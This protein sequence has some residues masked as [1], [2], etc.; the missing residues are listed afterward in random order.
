[1]GLR[2]EDGPPAVSR[3]AE[4]IRISL[5][6][7]VWNNVQRGTKLVI[8]S[9]HQLVAERLNEFAAERSALVV[10]NGEVL[11]DLGTAEFSL[12]AEGE[13]CVLQIWSEERNI[14]RRVLSAEVKNGILKLEVLRFGQ[15]KPA[16]LEICANP[17]PASAGVAAGPRRAARAQFQRLLRRLLEK[18]RPGW[19]LQSLVAAP[20]L[21]HSFGPAHVRG[22]IRRGSAAMAV[23]GVSPGEAQATVDGAVSAAVLWM[24]YCRQHYADRVHVEGARL[25]IPRGRSGAVRLRLSHLNHELAKWELCEFDQRAETVEEVSARDAGN[26]STRLVQAPDYARARERFAEAMALVRQILP[27]AEVEIVSAA[28]VSFRYHGLEFARAAVREVAGSFRTEAQL[29]FA[30]M[31][32]LAE[33]GA[34]IVVNAATEA[35]FREFVRQLSSARDGASGPSAGAAVAPAGVG[36]SHPLHRAVPER[37]L[38]AN[39]RRDPSLLDERLDPAAIY[40]QVPAFAAT[41]RAMIDLLGV[42]REGRLA[43][44]ELKVE[45]DIHLPLQGLDYWARVRWHQQRGEF[46]RFG[47]FPGREL[48][49]QPPLLLM[50]APCLHVH[51]TTDCLLRHLSPAIEWK[52]L[53]L[54]EHWRQGIRVIFRKT[55]SQGTGTRE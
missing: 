20:D 42:T 41:D 5:A 30:D 40:A 1:L 22:L 44:I 4:K 33:G 23:L 51:P 47:Y 35:R 12:R 10:E 48:T 16:K 14:V 46:Q 26:F 18:S 8:A 52:L 55:R 25:F 19:K 37:W 21:E 31:A 39:L 28:E 6:R 43:V 53:G 3:A 15:T 29:L 24:E 7:G 36:R 45:E 32:N 50:A 9:L 2:P 34:E 13:R 49:P 27:R 17:N 38:E 11:F 54:D